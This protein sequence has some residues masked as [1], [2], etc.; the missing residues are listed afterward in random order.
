MRTNGFDG[1]SSCQV[2]DCQVVPNPVGDGVR[3]P[4]SGASGASDGFGVGLGIGDGSPELPGVLGTGEGDP[5]GPDGLGVGW[6]LGLG[7]GANGRGAGAAGEAHATSRMTGRARPARARRAG[8]L[9]IR[10]YLGGATGTPQSR[11]RSLRVDEVA[12]GAVT[13]QVT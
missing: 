1:S 8:R 12:P 9:G 11:Y 5:A 3:K 13:R 6:P 4:P 2:I 7:G 10:W